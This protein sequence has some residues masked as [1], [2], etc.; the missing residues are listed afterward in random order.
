[1][2]GL[3]AEAGELSFAARVGEGE[4]RLWFR[5][6]TVPASTADPALATT[7]MPAMG[8]G[9]G[10][11]IPEPVSARLLRNQAEFQAIQRAWSSQWPF[12][13]PPL[14]EVD[15]SAPV[16]RAAGPKQPGR[17]A[18]FFSGGV[19]SWSVLLADPDVTDLVFVRGLDLVPGWSQHEALV[20]EVEARLRD[21]AA[22]LALPLH[23]VDTNVRS[24]SDPLVRWETYAASVLAAIALIFEPLFERV[25]IACDL[26]HGRQVPLGAAR[27]ID[28]LWSTEGLEIVDRGGR[29][30]RTE[31]LEQI[32]DHPLVQRTL[33]VCWQNPGGA[34]NCGRCGKCLLT[35]IALEAIGAREKVLTFPAE[36]DLRHLDSYTIST[37]LQVAFWEELL[38]TTQR[39]VRPDLE[40][41]VAAV[42]ETGHRALG[43]P[44]Y[45]LRRVLDSSSW[46]LTAPLRRLRGR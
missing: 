44:E 30:N 36:M 37:P 6:E 17:V 23:V 35:M 4:H 41:P 2:T 12:G 14:S 5:G 9:G 20:D 38:E 21:A 24:F 22:E 26:E 10:L 1:V 25:L 18:A 32:V 33:R 19:D 31:R 39:S 46:K 34:Y 29:F 43:G 8:R 11:A 7:L 16:R 13:L 28:Q 42:V 27:L 40:A 45:E 15:V 3:R